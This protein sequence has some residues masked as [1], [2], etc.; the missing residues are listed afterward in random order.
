MQ[1]HLNFLGDKNC[2][3]IKARNCKIGLLSET[4]FFSHN[5]KLFMFSPGN[6]GKVQ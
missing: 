3:H 4:T 1:L 2:M 6:N 5:I